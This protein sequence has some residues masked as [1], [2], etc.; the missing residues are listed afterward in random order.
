MAAV[1]AGEERPCSTSSWEWSP[2]RLDGCRQ[3][4]EEEGTWRT[5]DPKAKTSVVLMRIRTIDAA[6]TG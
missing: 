2:E 1:V 5:P 6:R 4:K 3:L